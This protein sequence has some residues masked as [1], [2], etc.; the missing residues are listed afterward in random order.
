MLREV[1]MADFMESWPL[2]I[3]KHY[4]RHYQAGFQAI[5]NMSSN[6]ADERE[7][8]VFALF[9]LHRR[10]LIHI[11]KMHPN[12]FNDPWLRKLIAPLGSAGG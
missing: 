12:V 10:V 5:V 6:S 7:E 4:M 2:A 8:K 9:K 11:V 1:T 3:R